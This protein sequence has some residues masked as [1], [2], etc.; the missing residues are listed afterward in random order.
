MVF[1]VGVQSV[2]HRREVIRNAHC[3]CKASEGERHAKYATMYDFAPIHVKTTL[4]ASG[5]HII[6]VAYCF[7]LIDHTWILLHADIVLFLIRFYVL[8]VCQYV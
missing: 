7:A 5:Q 8:Y 1:F 4:R 3:W 6:M 2:V